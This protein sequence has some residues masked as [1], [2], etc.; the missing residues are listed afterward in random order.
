MFLIS[1]KRDNLVITGSCRAYLQHCAALY[2]VFLGAFC[3]LLSGGCVG[4][5]EGL[6]GSVLSGI[7]V[8]VSVAVGGGSDIGIILLAADCLRYRYL[9][10]IVI[11]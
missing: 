3:C 10:M 2:K 5:S 1:L 6:S 9:C 11:S 7:A 4:N 8:A